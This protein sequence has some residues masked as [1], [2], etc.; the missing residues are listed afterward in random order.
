M[1]VRADAAH[2]LV[3][4]SRKVGVTHFSQNTYNVCIVYQFAPPSASYGDA[5]GPGYTDAGG[6]NGYAPDGLGIAD[7]AAPAG[8]SLAAGY[9]LSL[10]PGDA[11]AADALADG[12]AAADAPASP[13]EL[14]LGDGWVGALHAANPITTSAAPHIYATRCS[15]RS[16]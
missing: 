1:L 5:L 16:P 9:A 7:A 8:E 13:N 6:T 10:A 11:S 2:Q 14:A 12:I 3:A 4:T 15:M